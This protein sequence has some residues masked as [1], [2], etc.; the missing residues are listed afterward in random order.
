MDTCS[1]RLKI[2]FWIV[3]PE[4]MSLNHLRSHDN[5][6]PGWKAV[7]GQVPGRC[8][9][10]LAQLPCSCAAEQSQPRQGTPRLARWV[11]SHSWVPHRDDWKAES[12]LLRLAM[13]PGA[14]QHIQHLLWSSLLP[15]WWKVWKWATSMGGTTRND[16]LS[17]MHF[18]PLEEVSAQH[19]SQK[20]VYLPS[21]PQHEAGSSTNDDC[22]TQSNRPRQEPLL[23][24]D[25][26]TCLNHNVICHCFQR[27]GV[28]PSRLSQD[29]LACK[30][31]LL[32]YLLSPLDCGSFSLMCSLNGSNAF[33][34][35]P[36]PSF[37]SS[38]YP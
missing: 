24:Q 18:S 32:D 16:F 8:A 15:P 21:R 17:L 30:K 1:L 35:A 12:Y 28:Q 11:G 7:R 14:A 34:Q 38:S 5:R 25:C 4:L 19:F 37:T 23:W 13:G 36:V 29:F 33:L 3:S 27:C 10:A 20:I 2:H 22:R 6:I 9:A 31:V 26:F